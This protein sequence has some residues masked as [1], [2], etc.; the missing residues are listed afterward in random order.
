MFALIILAIICALIGF[1]ALSGRSRAQ[2]AATLS[3]NGVL[4]RALILQA[5]ATVSGRATVG[6][7]RF[8][9]R[10]LILDIELPG[11]APYEISVTPMIPRIVEAL[12]GAS[13]DVRV[14]PKSPNDVLIVGPAGSSAWLP[15]AMPFMQQVPGVAA[16]PSGPGL[17][18]FFI[19]LSLTFG[20]IAAAVG[21]SDSGEAKPKGGYC[22]AAT[23]CCKA[24][25]QT[26]CT[27]YESL[28]EKSCEA[29]FK[30][31][32]AQAAK[33]HNKCD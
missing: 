16:T 32:K 25:G 9:M 14:D 33:L 2:Q 21:L 22:A 23:R 28:S 31:L 15:A 24:A 13:V 17:G 27:K 19:L 1:G 5:A 10:N 26:K 29:S 18:I 3:T 4:G 8:E 12:P 11:Q 6:G 20:G 7:Q 30:T